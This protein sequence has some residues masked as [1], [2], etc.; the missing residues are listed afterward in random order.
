M[1]VVRDMIKKGMYKND[2]NSAIINKLAILH[3]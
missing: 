1:S 2:P 3:Q